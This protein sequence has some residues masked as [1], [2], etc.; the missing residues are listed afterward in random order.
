M[1]DM[2]FLKF[3]PSTL[4]EE[5]TSG[6]SSGLKKSV[7]I[8]NDVQVRVNED[9]EPHVELQQTQP[10]PQLV[11]SFKAAVGN[12]AQDHE[13]EH[14]EHVLQDT[15]VYYHF[16]LYFCIQSSISQDWYDPTEG[17]GEDT[18]FAS[19]PTLV[20]ASEPPSPDRAYG[21]PA[22]PGQV[23][24]TMVSTLSTSIWLQS[25]YGQYSRPIIQ[26]ITLVVQQW[27][28]LKNQFNPKLS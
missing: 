14:N 4:L 19:S 18:H 12:Q 27:C 6:S 23:E 13:N 5:S 7:M 26:L 20:T 11:T 25:I 15:V 17:L 21:E 2:N 28:P 1:I 9:D 3:L 10:R 16:V 24:P 22:L 8:L